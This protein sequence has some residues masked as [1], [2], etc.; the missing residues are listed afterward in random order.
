MRCAAY[1]ARKIRIAEILP[2]SDRIGH[3]AARHSM[4][5]S[6]MLVATG[7]LDR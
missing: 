2:V 1:L 5:A 3:L 6:A 7:I 4:R